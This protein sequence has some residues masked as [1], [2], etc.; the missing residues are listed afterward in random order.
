MTTTYHSFITHFDD[1]EALPGYE[2]IRQRF[3]QGF[4]SFVNAKKYQGV[5]A[6]LPTEIQSN[7][8]VKNPNFIAS[9]VDVVPDDALLEKSFIFLSLNPAAMV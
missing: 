2:G 5:S 3:L 8:L 9:I 7:T 6:L 4:G 1:V